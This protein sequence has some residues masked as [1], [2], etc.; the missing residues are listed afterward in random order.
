MKNRPLF[1]TSARKLRQGS[2]ARAAFSGVCRCASTTARAPAPKAASSVS[3]RRSASGTLPPTRTSMAPAAAS[4]PPG[5]FL[6]HIP[7][8]AQ[9]PASTSSPWLNIIMPSERPTVP[10]T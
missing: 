3:T 5:H 10:H 2:A 9:A 6:G 7:H 8:S 1:F 4:Q